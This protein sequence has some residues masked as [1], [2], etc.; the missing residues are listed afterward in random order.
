MQAAIEPVGR[1]YAECTP[2]SYTADM[3][4]CGTRCRQAR[5]RGGTDQSSDAEMGGQWP[6]TAPSRR[7]RGSSPRRTYRKMGAASSCTMVVHCGCSTGDTVYAAIDMERRKAIQSVSS[8]T[9]HLLDTALKKVPATIQAALQERP[10]AL[11]TSPTL[12]PYLPEE[13]RQVGGARTT[14]FPGLS[15]G[16]GDNAHRGG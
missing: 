1:D 8:S 16:D 7:R 15:R 6:T 5:G 12:R 4:S 13:P 14:P 3:R 10:P 11:L 2:R 9:T